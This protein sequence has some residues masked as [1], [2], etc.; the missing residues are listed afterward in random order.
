[1]VN[2]GSE[3]DKKEVKV[4]TAMST[5]VREILVKLLRDFKDVFAWS[6]QDMSGL[7]PEI[8]QHKLS[9]KP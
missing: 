9:L 6:Y 1:M 8:A 2:L 3:D 4:G 5:A 7:D